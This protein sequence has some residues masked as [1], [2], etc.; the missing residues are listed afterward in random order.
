MRNLMA[1]G[2]H[3]TG[4]APPS[5][6]FG[7]ARQVSN[8]AIMLCSLQVQPTFRLWKVAFW[9]C[10]GGLR[11]A[12]DLHPTLAPMLGSERLSHFEVTARRDLGNSRISSIVPRLP[13]VQA[14]SVV[15]T[16]PGSTGTCSRCRLWFVP[17][18]S[19]HAVDPMVLNHLIFALGDRHPA[20]TGGLGKGQ[21]QEGHRNLPHV[22]KQAERICTYVSSITSLR[23]LQISRA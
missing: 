21:R 18:P 17:Q 9:P 19:G 10:V 6:D 13:S 16:V 11:Q 7:V 15:V 2:T 4:P 12:L 22:P 14:V 20:V 5:V 23:K 3:I 8:A 1:H